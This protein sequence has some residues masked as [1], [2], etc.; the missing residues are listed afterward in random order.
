VTTAGFAHIA[1][2]IAGLS[3]PTVIVQEGGYLSDHLADNL[4]MF[5]T[6]YEGALKPPVDT[7]AE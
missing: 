2:K 5:L 3:L 7:T 6:S 4:A 1:E